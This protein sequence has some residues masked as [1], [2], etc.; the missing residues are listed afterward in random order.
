MH[1][2]ATW[3]QISHSIA[4]SSTQYQH[5]DWGIGTSG[6]INV[7]TLRFYE[8]ERLLRRPL[9]TPAGYRIYG[10]PDL[11]RIRFIR[12]CQ[13]LGFTLSEIRVLSQLHDTLRLPQ[14]LRKHAAIVVLIFSHAHESAGNVETDEHF[15]QA[16]EPV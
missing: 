5:E 9:R 6:G 12:L 15:D 10:H 1:A 8:R 11:E 16:Q 2:T 3:V 7:Q 14:R 4:H 13:G